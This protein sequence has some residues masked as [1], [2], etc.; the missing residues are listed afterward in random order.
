[1][2]PYGFYL[3]WGGVTFISNGNGGTAFG[4]LD[5]TGM[6][7][8]ALVFGAVAAWVGGWIV[9]EGRT[10]ARYA[11]EALGAISLILGVLALVGENLFTNSTLWQGVLAAFIATIVLMWAIAI[12]RH[13]GAVGEGETH[14]P[15]HR[16]SEQCWQGG[17]ITTPP[18][19][20]LDVGNHFYVAETSLTSRCPAGRR[21]HL[22]IGGTYRRQGLHALNGRAI[23][24]SRQVRNHRA[25]SDHDSDNCSRQI[26]RPEG[27]LVGGEDDCDRRRKP[28]DRNRGG[29]DPGPELDL[30][31]GLVRQLARI[32][33]GSPPA[34]DC[35]IT[36]TPIA[37][38]FTL[39]HA[40]ITVHS[41]A[42]VV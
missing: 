18:A 3:A 26:P 35:A 7:G 21:P 39:S 28:D 4:L 24:R 16:P 12:G 31:P 17:A 32:E 33:D 40:A 23:R 9:F 10:V 34:T 22:T 1:V 41:P 6:A 25:P 27:A 38:G 11:T 5:P 15:A 20:V 2:V 37:S 29:G 30:V 19:V 14:I 42:N 13:S 36:P 8:W